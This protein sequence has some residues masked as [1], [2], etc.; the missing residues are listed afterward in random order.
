MI[1]A[2]PPASNGVSG[3]TQTAGAIPTTRYSYI[4]PFASGRTNGLAEPADD[5][6]SLANDSSKQAI[7]SVVSQFDVEAALLRHGAR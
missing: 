6:V 7:S 1:K 5:I 3:S 2:C 4:A